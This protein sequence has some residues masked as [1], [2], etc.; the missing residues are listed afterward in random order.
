MVI[1]FLFNRK[2][3]KKNAQGVNLSQRGQE[4]VDKYSCFLP[5]AMFHLDSQNVSNKTDPIAPN[6]DL[7]IVLFVNFLSSS[8]TFLV[9]YHDITCQINSMYQN[10]CSEISCLYF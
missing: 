10:T 3:Q 4:L 9:T 8:L 7:V 2:F 6:G 1:V 5:S